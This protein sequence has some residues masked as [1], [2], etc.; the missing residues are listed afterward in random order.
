MASG[1]NSLSDKYGSWICTQAF[2]SSNSFRRVRA[3]LKMQSAHKRMIFNRKIEQDENN[4][5]DDL[6]FEHLSW[7]SVSVDN[8]AWITPSILQKLYTIGIIILICR[9]LQMW[10]QP[11]LK[12]NKWGERMRRK[13]PVVPVNVPACWEGWC[14]HKNPTL[15]SRIAT[16]GKTSPVISRNMR[17]DTHGLWRNFF[18][19]F[20]CSE[21][22]ARAMSNADDPFPKGYGNLE[23]EQGRKSGVRN[24][25]LWG[26]KQTN[27][28][29]IGAIS[30]GD[31]KA[32][33]GFDDYP[34]IDGGYLENAEKNHRISELKRIE[35]LQFAE[36]RIQV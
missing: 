36:E 28:K 31:Y 26:K 16:R 10:L 7:A 1:T 3:N 2:G 24:Q 9:P 33:T 29:E 13:W 22:P 5:N 14:T 20:Y 34:Q 4:K 15:K 21:L 27:I 30:P 25:L 12:E 6:W 17:D 11:T 32:K 23:R 18:S 8:F 35:Y 19:K